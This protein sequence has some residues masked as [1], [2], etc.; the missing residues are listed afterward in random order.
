M[1]PKAQQRS[2]YII[3]LL[4]CATGVALIVLGALKENIVFFVTPSEWIEKQ[5]D[6]AHVGTKKLRLGGKVEKQSLTKEK[7][8]ITFKITDY[9]HSISVTYQGVVPDLFR[10]DQG[11]V[12]EGNFESNGSF[13]AARILAKH[14][15]NYMPKEVAD[16]LKEKNLWQGKALKAES[17][18]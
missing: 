4:M 2:W 6:Y 3:A 16:K 11:V 17:K 18:A 12:A 8:I 10:E 1:N 7:D 13:K 9:K 15:E 5:K 14:D